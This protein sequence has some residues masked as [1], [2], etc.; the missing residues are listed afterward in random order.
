MC[1]PMSNPNE[2]VCGI[3]EARH[4]DLVQ[5]LGDAMI[6]VEASVVVVAA[7]VW[8]LGHRDTVDAS[9]VIGDVVDAGTSTEGAGVVVENEGFDERRKE[10]RRRSN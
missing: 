7:D 10:L 3:D 6:G 2:V 4:G 8:S 5:R 1:L 9:T